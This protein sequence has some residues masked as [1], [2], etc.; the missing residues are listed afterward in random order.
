MDE[1]FAAFLDSP[2]Q[3]VF[4]KSLIQ[5]ADADGP[6]YLCVSLSGAWEHVDRPKEELR[7]VFTEEM[8]R[9]FPAAREAEIARFLV[10]KERRATFRSIP[11][12]AAHRLPQTTHIPN[13]FLAGDWTRTGWPS[14][15]EGAVLSGV[16]AA[17]ALAAG[18]RQPG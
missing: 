4:N 2:V 5:G 14:T 1:T 11:G 12:A 6:Q 9:L 15:M 18:F 10:V 13:L 8:A 17:D 7:R 3:W 16:L